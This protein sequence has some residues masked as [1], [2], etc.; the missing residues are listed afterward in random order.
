MQFNPD[1]TKQAVQVTFSQK[2]IKTTHP[3][4]Y[5][6][7]TQVVIKQ[8][9]KASRI[10][11]GFWPNFPQT[12]E[13]KDYQCKKGYWCNPIPIKVCNEGCSGSNI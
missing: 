8:E 10:D 11:F 9:K 3:P 2:R 12:R 5:F 13:G 1:R 4:L 6:N 7:E